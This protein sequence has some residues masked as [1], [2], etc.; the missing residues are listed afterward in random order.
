[1]KAK[2]TFLSI[3][4]AALLGVG[5][6]MAFKQEDKPKKYLTVCYREHVKFV[7]GINYILSV[8][9][10]NNKK[11]EVESAIQNDPALIVNKVI[12]EYS[13]KGY[14]FISL[15]VNENQTTKGVGLGFYMIFEKE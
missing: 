1:M 8:Y 4:I 3:A 5:I 12:N 15:N 13:S 11:T 9:D 7:G 2:L 6:L 10:E 14:K